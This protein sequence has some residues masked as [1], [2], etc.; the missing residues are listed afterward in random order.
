MRYQVEL[1]GIEQSVIQQALNAGEPIPD[2]FKNKPRLLK[3]GLFYFGAFFD[4][5]TE[6]NHGTGLMKIPRHAIIAYGKECGLIGEELYDLVYVIRR[7]DDAHIERLAEE[8][9]RDANA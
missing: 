5:D 7:V 2:E 4:L 9:K 3:T 1:G 6:R 8:M